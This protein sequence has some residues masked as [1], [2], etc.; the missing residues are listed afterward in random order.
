M[1]IRLESIVNAPIDKVKSHFAKDL[2]TYL[3]PPG[4]KLL[5]FDGSQTGDIV[6][7]RL[8]GAG[9]WMSEIVSH[10]EGEGEWY[11]VDQGKILPMG[12]KAGNMNTD[13]R[14]EGRIPSLSTTCNLVRERNGW[15]HYY[16]RFFIFRF[17]P[18]NFNTTDTFPKSEDYSRFLG[19]LSAGSTYS[20]VVGYANSRSSC[21]ANSFKIFSHILCSVI[22]RFF[23]GVR[24]R[25][26]SITP[27]SFT[28]RYTNGV[29]CE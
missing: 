26:V 15:T 12:L 6:H 3:L 2:F 19:L 16:T 1:T 4:A 22:R 7:L 10:G 25:I 5:R 20:R 28:D 11:F 21:F 27:L 23:G 24:Y 18:E 9:E 14:T 8:P 13:F 29:N 17:I